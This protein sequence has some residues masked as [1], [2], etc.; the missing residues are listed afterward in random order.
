LFIR[1]G[2]ANNHRQN[3]FIRQPATAAGCNGAGFPVSMMDVLFMKYWQARV[4][5]NHLPLRR[6]RLVKVKTDWGSYELQLEY[7][8][9]GKYRYVNFAK[10]KRVLNTAK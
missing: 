5:R 3:H 7:S 9:M 8:V 1:F 6:K 2:A 10:V 4:K